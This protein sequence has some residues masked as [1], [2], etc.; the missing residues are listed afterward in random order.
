MV[1]SIVCLILFPFLLIM[2]SVQ[3]AYQIPDDIDP[4]TL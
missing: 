4:D 3:S 1:K 2:R